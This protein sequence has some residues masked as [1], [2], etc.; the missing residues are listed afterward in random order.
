MNSSLLPDSLRHKPGSGFVPDLVGSFLTTQEVGRLASTSRNALD[1]FGSGA[2]IGRYGEESFGILE[3]K[4]ARL[5]FLLDQVVPDSYL[6]L[7]SVDRVRK[8]LREHIRD[9]FVNFM[10]ETKIYLVEV[11][12]IRNAS[13]RILALIIL[14]IIDGDLDKFPQDQLFPL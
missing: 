4:K 7:A 9:Y 11:E 12:N 6:D 14:M 10:F 1:E 5:L 2:R 13:A 8:T 3:H